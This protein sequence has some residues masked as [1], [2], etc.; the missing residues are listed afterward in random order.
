MSV[1]GLLADSPNAL[2]LRAEGLR[3]PAVPP[4]WGHGPGRPVLLIPGVYESWWFLHAIGAALHDDGHPVHVIE[5]IG[6]NAGPIP[7]V[8]RQAHDLLAERDVRGA[9]VV[10]HSK[11]GIVGKHLLVDEL[12]V[13]EPDRRVAHVIAIASPF[14][15]SRMARLAP[16]GALRAFLPGDA[17]LG[18]LAAE[19]AVDA[20]ITSVYPRTDPHIPE[21][22]RLPGAENIEIDTIGHFRV[23]RDPRTVAV[24]RRVAGRA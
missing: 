4:A 18:R 24:V 15:G 22:S 9:V 12:A 23:L 19:R 7:W 2:R 6:R 17:L 13:P 3:I 14:A 16:V 21:G 20:R 8:A 1:R 5:A 11:G 10:A